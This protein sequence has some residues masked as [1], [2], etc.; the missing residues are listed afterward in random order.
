MALVLTANRL[1]T[2]ASFIKLE[3]TVFS[4]PLIYAGALLGVDD[5]LSARLVLLILMAAIG[6]RVAAL[7]FNRLIDVGIDR[8][9]PRTR[10][11][12][13]PRGAMQR[14]EGWLVVAIGGALYL[15]SAAAIAPICLQLAPIPLV[16]FAGYPYLK[17]F[18]SL[19]HLGLGLAWSMAPLGGWLAVSHSL[20]NLGEIGW[21]WL[22][23]VLW[24]A[25]FDMLYSLQDYEFDSQLGLQSAAVQFGE[26]GA[27]LT[28]GL[29]HL[30]ALLS[31]M[32]VGILAGLGWI[33]GSGLL[34][35]FGFLLREHWLVHRFGTAQMNQAFFAM[36]AGVSIAVFLFAFLD[37]KLR[38]MGQ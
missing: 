37:L 9:N 29:L 6:G 19:S 35:V 20:A 3:H 10:I 23:S 31:W 2:Y 25:G 5:V 32:G 7:G 24:V 1:K 21:L 36:N 4:L 13:L 22:F 26:R 12:E 11:R 14:W 30:A 15:A 34:L 38:S 33:Y 17:R 16:L 8:R 27:L 18:T 28:A